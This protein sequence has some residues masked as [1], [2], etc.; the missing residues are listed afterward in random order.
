MGKEAAQQTIQQI[1]LVDD[2]QLQA[3]VSGIGHEDGHGLRAAQPA[4]G[5]SRGERRLG[6]RLR[7]ARRIHLRHARPP[8]LHQRRGGAGHG[9]RPRDRPRDQPALGAADQQGADRDARARVSA[10]CSRSDVAQAGRAWPARA[11][12]CCSSST[13]AM[14]RIRPTWPD[15]ATRSARTT[16]CARWGTCSTRSTGWARRPAGA[17][18][19]NWLSTHPAPADR[20]AATQADSI[21]CT[22]I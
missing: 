9:R 6:Q 7:A 17:S 5:I 20:V 13:A 4:V 3:Y 19:P 1:G 16:T 18:C 10:A 8:H 21:R 11:C 22:R 12:R 2:P 14:P 15:S